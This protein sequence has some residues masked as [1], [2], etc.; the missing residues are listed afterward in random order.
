MMFDW[1]EAATI[2]RGIGIDLAGKAFGWL[3][4]LAGLWVAVAVI[5]GSVTMVGY[6]SEVWP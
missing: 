4:V 3:I 5:V 1:T 6:I 2:A